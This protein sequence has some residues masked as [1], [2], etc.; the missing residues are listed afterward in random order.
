M[1]SALRGVRQ[2]MLVLC[3][4]WST[5]APFLQIEVVKVS[6]ATCSHKWSS[7]G[8]RWFDA[9]RAARCKA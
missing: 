4:M 9:T 2:R 1:A 6:M 7:K 8:M 5:K 3:T